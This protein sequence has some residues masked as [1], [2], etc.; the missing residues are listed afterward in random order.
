MIPHL[1]VALNKFTWVRVKCANRP[2]KRE[3]HASGAQNGHSRFGHVQ[4]RSIW[5]HKCQG[6]SIV[7]QFIGDDPN[8]LGFAGS[9]A[10]KTKIDLLMGI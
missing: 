5:V 8:A 3:R 10:E 9:L 1:D 6:L 4:S 7:P 2:I